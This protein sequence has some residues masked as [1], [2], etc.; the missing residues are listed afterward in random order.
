M[1]TPEERHEICVGLYVSLIATAFVILFAATGCNT[2]STAAPPS[3]E[4]TTAPS[5]PCGDSCNCEQLKLQLAEKDAK[6]AECEA[7]AARLESK[8]AFLDQEI[9]DLYRPGDKVQHPN[10]HYELKWVWVPKPVQQSAIKP[11]KVQAP[12]PYMSPCGPGG[13]PSPAMRGFFGRR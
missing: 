5:C 13:C 4:V 11:K 9:S 8:A 1:T 3:Y 2:P 7:V 10:G 6:L 12:D